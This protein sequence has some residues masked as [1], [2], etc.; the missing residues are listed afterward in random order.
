M[1]EILQQNLTLERVADRK[2][3]SL[4]RE[5]G[6][7]GRIFGCQHNDLGRPFKDLRSSYRACTGC[8]ARKRFDTESFKTL[9]NF[10]YPPSAPFSR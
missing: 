4:G 9:G 10:Y 6:I 5:I 3:S 1:Q 7:L 2:E 8:G